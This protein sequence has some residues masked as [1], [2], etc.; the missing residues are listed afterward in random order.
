VPPQRLEAH[1]PADA[2]SAATLVIDSRGH[3]DHAYEHAA[4]SIRTKI[5]IITHN[6]YSCRLRV[7]HRVITPCAPLPTST[8]P[9]PL[10]PT[11]SR[12]LPRSTC[13]P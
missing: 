9:L 11:P 12:S 7:P 2:K 8:A 5:T 10:L 6:N 13:G 1:I 3:Q 4:P